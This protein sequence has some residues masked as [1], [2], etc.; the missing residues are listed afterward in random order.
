MERIENGQ[1]TD[2]ED[3]GSTSI[4]SQRMNSLEAGPCRERSEHWP[5]S[6]FSHK[7]RLLHVSVDMV[8]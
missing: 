5:E 8:C 3:L 2:P 6:G 1:A 7:P 4:P